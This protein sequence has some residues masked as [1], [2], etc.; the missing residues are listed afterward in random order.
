MLFSVLWHEGIQFAKDCE[1]REGP[2]IIKSTVLVGYSLGG[3]EENHDI[4][5]WK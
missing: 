3:A 5:Q 2:G 1:A 4:S